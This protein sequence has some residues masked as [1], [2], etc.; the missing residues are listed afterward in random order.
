MQQR[1]T[2]VRAGWQSIDCS[3]DAGFMIGC[4]EKAGLVI[5]CSEKAGFMIDG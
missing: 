3:E 2:C 4:S 1:Q 5:G